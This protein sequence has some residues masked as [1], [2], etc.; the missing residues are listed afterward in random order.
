MAGLRSSKEIV[1]FIGDS[2]TTKCCSLC[3][4][5]GD[6]KPDILVERLAYDLV[7]SVSP[8]ATIQGAQ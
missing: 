5:H 3:M 2:H 6:I 4:V 8:V 7:A 1:A